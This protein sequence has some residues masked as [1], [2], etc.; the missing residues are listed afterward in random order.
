M[1]KLTVSKM[2]ISIVS[3]NYVYVHNYVA[4]FVIS[5]MITTRAITAKP[6]AANMLRPNAHLP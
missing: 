3:I 5:K 1:C 4:E 2:Y 6:N